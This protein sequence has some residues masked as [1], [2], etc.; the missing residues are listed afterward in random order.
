MLAHLCRRSAVR[1]GTQ[2]LHDGDFTTRF[3]EMG[4]PELD[5]LVS[6]YNRMMDRLREERIRVREQHQF[7]D[8][9][10]K[11]SPSGVIVFDYDHRGA[12]VNPASE[13]ILGVRA[14][15]IAGKRLSE[16]GEPLLGTLAGLGLH[17][18]RLVP[19][20]GARRARAH[21][22]QFRDR[23]FVR[24]FLVIEELTEK[25]RRSEKAAYEKIIRLMSH[26]INDSVGA[27]NS[28]LESCLSYRSQLR[29]E[30]RADFET[31]LQVAISR[32]NHLNAF[33]RAYADVIRL[34]A[35]DRRPCDLKQLLDDIVFL[36]RPEA[37]NRRVQLLWEPPEAARIVALDRYQMEQVFLNILHNAL[38]AIGADGAITVQLNGQDSTPGV[39]IEDTGRG[40]PDEAREK[41]FTPFFST[42]E[43]GRGIGL[44]LTREILTNHGFR[45]SLESRPGGPTQFRIWLGPGA[46][47]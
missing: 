16:T 14:T 45:S 23:G 25:L 33:V 44:T 15:H 1:T 10:I 41:L 22:S 28:L 19:L 21:K 17:E 34:P 2:F 18:P 3:S 32:M 4:Q 30:D 36:L 8:E 24:H 20:E 13:R 39:T 43:N 29:A 35:P 27:A 42:K 46:L 31:A 12:L 26:E 11:A 38:E 9:I 7:L 5:G 6:V 40:I 47:R 37:Q